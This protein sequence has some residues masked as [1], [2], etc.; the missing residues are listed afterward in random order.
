ME[1]RTE[2][3]KDGKVVRAFGMDP[4][5]PRVLACCFRLS[6]LGHVVFEQTCVCF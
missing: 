5:H 4:F 2:Q 1:L 3:G 6:V